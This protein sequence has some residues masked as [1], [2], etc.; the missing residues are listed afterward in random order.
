MSRAGRATVSRNALKH[1]LRGD[2]SVV[3]GVEDP[4]EWKRHL[5]AVAA[6]IAP[7]G[8][9]E[10]ELTRV[11]A[12][13]LWRRRR[14]VAAESAV[15]ATNVADRG[16]PRAFQY[17]DAKGCF[18]DAMRRLELLNIAE[19]D[20]SDLPLIRNET[21]RR[22]GA[23]T[24]NDAEWVLSVLL[25]SPMDSAQVSAFMATV[26]KSWTTA[27]ELHSLVNPF[28]WPLARRILEAELEEQRA[29]WLAVEQEARRV[30]VA[31]L[32]PTESQA[33]I[34]TRYEA[35]I[36]RTI[37]RCLTELERFQR[38][39]AGETIPPPLKVTLAAE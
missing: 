4:A 33:A 10:A 34:L 32:L 14:L 36:D 24:P 19:R 11:L 2:G 5:A 29:I 25:P 12:E 8:Y 15:L 30:A 23:F 27:R 17:D 3:R 21:P 20:P 28:A 22:A 9:I 31:C 35:N 18:E 26:K 37:A 1:G 7:Q 6:D 16:G 13:A 39:R 38:M